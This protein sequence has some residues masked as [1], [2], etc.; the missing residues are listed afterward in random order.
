MFINGIPMILFELKN[1]ANEDTTITNAYNQIQNY[2]LDIPKLFW[3][4]AF[5]V[6]SD[7]LSTKVGTITSDFTRYM[8]WKSENGETD[9]DSI[10]FYSTMLN[11]MFQRRLLDIIKILLFIRVL[12]EKQ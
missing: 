6:I 7:G 1:A 4:N 10:D 11:G 9:E 3:Y 2:M 5:N 8:A 12:T